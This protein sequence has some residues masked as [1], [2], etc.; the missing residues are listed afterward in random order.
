MNILRW[1]IGNGYRVANVFTEDH[2]AL[3]GGRE[4]VF[5]GELQPETSWNTNVNYVKKIVRENSFITFDASAFYTY[6]DNRILPDYETDTN[7][8][9]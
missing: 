4:V 2:A 6:F 5:N 7:K 3:T 8:K 1:S 9:S